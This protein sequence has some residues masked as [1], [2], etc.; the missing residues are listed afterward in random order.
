M[1]VEPDLDSVK[2]LSDG[3]QEKIDREKK[4]KKRIGRGNNPRMKGNKSWEITDDDLK[5]ELASGVLIR[6]HIIQMNHLN[7]EK[8]I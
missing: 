2:V 1:K 3:K 8:L 5:K 4:P 7:L 6:Y